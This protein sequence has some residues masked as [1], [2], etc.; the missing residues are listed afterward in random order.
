MDEITVFPQP[1][2]RLRLEELNSI[3]SIKSCTT[4]WLWHRRASGERNLSDQLVSS[5]T[6]MIAGGEIA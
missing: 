4:G 6:V 1:I 3:H 2:D 5:C